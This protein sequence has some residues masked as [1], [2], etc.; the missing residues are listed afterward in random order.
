MKIQ[1]NPL[2][3]PLLSSRLETAVTAVG[4]H[5][6]NQLNPLTGPLHSSRLEITVPADGVC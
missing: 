3:G 5:D 2:T 4:A 6:S 1:L